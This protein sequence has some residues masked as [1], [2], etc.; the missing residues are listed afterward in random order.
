MSEIQSHSIFGHYNQI[1]NRVTAALLQILKLGGAEFIGNVLSQIQSIDF[2]SNEINVTTQEKEGNNVYDGS[3][4]CD[5]KFKVLV[6]IKIKK[7][8]INQKQLEGLK[9]NASHPHDYILYI[10]PDDV[11]P[12]ELSVVEKGK[13]IYWVNWKTINDILKKKD[14]KSETLNFL[15][16]EFEKYLDFLNLLEVVSKDERVQIAAGS[17]GEPVALKYGFYACQNNRPVKECKYLAFY[18][19]GE[20]N[21][22]FEI[23]EGPINDVEITSKLDEEQ[24]GQYKE[25]FGD[26]HEGSS[27][28][29]YRLKLYKK[30]LS[31]KNVTKNKSG[32][33]AAYTMGVF[34]YTTIQK[35][36]DAK[37]TD[38]L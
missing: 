31:I 23:V 4:E 30:D 29:Y 3:L 32:G 18:N 27:H 2:P 28:Q 37:T 24:R 11:M 33:N 7:G 25:E 20:I 12:K 8:A 34:R 36:M 19:K 35:I 15:I 26:S 9:K 17:F 10:T 21:H 1:E 6:E 16:Q 5:F 14:T 38:Q 22:L 13:P